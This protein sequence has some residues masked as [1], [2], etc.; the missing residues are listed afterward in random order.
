L[1]C[2]AGV[3][4]PPTVVVLG[5]A[6]DLRCTR[7]NIGIVVITIL[8]A[9]TRSS[10]AVSILVFVFTGGAL[11]VDLS[12]AVVIE[13]VTTDLLGREDFSNTFSPLSVLTSLRTALTAP[14]VLCAVG[15]LVALSLKIVD[16]PVTVVIFLVTDLL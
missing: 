3:I 9:G 8:F 5:V 2:I 6:T 12:V 16:F 1:P 15:A 10:S 11:F 13:F 14:L 4:T 7:I